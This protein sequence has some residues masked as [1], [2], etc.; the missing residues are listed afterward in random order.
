MPSVDFELSPLRAF[1][2]TRSDD[3]LVIS[4]VVWFLLAPTCFLNV[5]E[6]IVWVL[7]GTGRVWGHSQ[8]LTDELSIY[9][10]TGRCITSMYPW[11][12]HGDPYV[13]GTSHI[14]TKFSLFFENRNQR[15]S[16]SQHKAPIPTVLHPL[17]GRGT[18]K[19]PGK[20]H[21]CHCRKCPFRSHCLYYRRVL[22]SEQPNILLLVPSPMAAIL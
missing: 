2:A 12:G 15:A 4:N 22:G 8:K 20:Q 16:L 13:S 7:N 9:L 14:G 11:L 5:G 17:S 1:T 18:S 10:I 6:K 21:L 19:C 3:S